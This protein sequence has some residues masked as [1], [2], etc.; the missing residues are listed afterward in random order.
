MNF[1]ERLAQFIFNFLDI[2]KSPHPSDCIFVPAGGQERKAYGIKMWRFGFAPRLV[3][4]VGRFEWRRCGELNLEVD[5]GLEALATQTPP[6]KQH[7]LIGL[8]RQETSC[9]PVRVGRLQIR[10][11]ARIL[12]EYL[13]QMPVRSLLV[14][15]SP[16]QLKRASLAFHRA[17]R[18]SGIDLKFVAV[19]EN[20]RVSSPAV[21][22]QV[23]S[24][25]IKYLG[26]RIF[27]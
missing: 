3:L 5:G 14:V 13:K 23:Y 2:G 11:E 16:L 9:I 24:E 26:S 4:S 15:S 20:L 8:N 19:P 27:L 6:E 12:A 17:F 21:R 18:K 10:S 7:F 1:R 22:A 25:L